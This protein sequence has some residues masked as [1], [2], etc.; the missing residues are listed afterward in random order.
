MF[1]QAGDDLLRGPGR[2]PPAEPAAGRCVA[3]RELMH[4]ARNLN[5]PINAARF[6]KLLLFYIDNYINIIVINKIYV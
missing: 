6:T 1:P 3:G 5:V 2:H 4:G